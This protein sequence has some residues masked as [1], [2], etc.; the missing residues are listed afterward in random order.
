M[1]RLNKSTTVPADGEGR[2]RYNCPCG[3]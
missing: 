3:W 1:V 2:Q